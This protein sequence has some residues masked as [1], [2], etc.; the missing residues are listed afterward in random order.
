M[1]QINCS[2][3]EQEIKELLVKG[4][5]VETILSKEG[6][7][8]QIFLLKKKGRGTEASDKPEEPQYL[9]TSGP[10]QNGGSS[11]P[12]RPHPSSG[13]DDKNGLEGCLPSGTNPPAAPT[14]PASMELESL[15][16]SMRSIQADISTT[17]FFKGHETCSGDVTLRHM[18]IRLIIYLDNILILYQVKEELIQAIPLICQFFETLGLVINQKKS[19]LIP[20]QRME[21]LGFLV[22]AKHCI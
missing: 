10:L 8:S 13:L 4:A 9:C 20:Q 15:S 2:T 11:H 16:V 19:I 18:G 12:S 6:F 21:F 1:P 3:E 22:D 7:V 17:G 14:P 5:I